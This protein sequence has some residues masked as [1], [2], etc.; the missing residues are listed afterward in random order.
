MQLLITFTILLISIILF[1]SNRL[2]TDLV[3]ILAL[4]A[5]VLTGII[6]V[7]EAFRGFANPIVIMIVG[8]FIIGAGIYRTGLAQMAGT[9]LIKCSKDSE[10]RLFILLLVIVAVTGA[11]M[12]NTGTVALMIPIVVSIA[13]RMN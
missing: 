3:A 8:L 12:S 1:I 11:F 5:L 13:L 2:R 10:K 7:E 4:L 9:L 6:N